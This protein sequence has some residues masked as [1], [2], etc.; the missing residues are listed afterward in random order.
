[1][2]FGTAAVFVPR[3][4]LGRTMKANPLVREQEPIRST[5]LPYGKQTIDEDDRRAV[6]NVLRGNWLTTG[7]A[8]S[9]FEAVLCQT[10]GARQAVAMSS[11]T[12]ALHA[13]TTAIDIQP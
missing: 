12:A 2:L 6:E 10:T 1:M 4:F 11:G 5:M 8:V 9:S 7:P 13:A 3:L